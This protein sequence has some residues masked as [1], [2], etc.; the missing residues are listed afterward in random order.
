MRPSKPAGSLD[1][2]KGAGDYLTHHQDTYKDKFGQRENSKLSP[3]DLNKL[4]GIN[5][6]TG[7][8][9]TNYYILDGDYGLTS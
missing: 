2:G 1:I 5:F 4:K 9:S 7:F 8:Q 6:S 3:A